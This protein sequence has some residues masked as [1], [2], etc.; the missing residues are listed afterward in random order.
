MRWARSGFPT[1]PRPAISAGGVTRR[2]SKRCRARL[3]RRGFGSGGAQPAGFL[4]EAVIDADGTLAETTA[5][6]KEGDGRRV[7]RRVGLSPAGGVIGEHRGASVFGQPEWQSSLFGGRR[8]AVRSGAGVVSRGR[9]PAHHVSAAIRI[10]RRRS[11]WIGG[12]PMACGSS[13]GTM[14]ARISS[15]KPTR[16]PRA[17]GPA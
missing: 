6:C 8:R 16:C 7:Y 1:R 10:F 5:A 17:R 2:R 15:A 9:V 11:I 12:T 14:R 3:T 4:D 13:S